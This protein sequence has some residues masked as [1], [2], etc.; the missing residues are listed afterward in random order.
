MGLAEIVVDSS[1]IVA[2]LADEPDRARL[3][4]ALKRANIKETSPAVRLEAATVLASRLQVSPEDS[5]LAI[6]ALLVDAQIVVIDLTDEI[7]QAAVRAF[8]RYGKG[9]GHPAQLNFGDCL[10]Y[11]TAKTRARALLFVG[12]DFSKT[13]IR[14]A[15]ENSD[16]T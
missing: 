7:A 15:L 11:A 9:R 3:I 13:D 16:P 10:V 8:T 14:S 4:A 2:I 12:D 6:S 1:A 5:N